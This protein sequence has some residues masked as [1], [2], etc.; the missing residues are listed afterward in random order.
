MSFETPILAIACGPTVTTW[1]IAKSTT[2]QQSSTFDVPSLVGTGKGIEQF[3]P[4]GNDLVNDLAWNHNGQVIV[5]CSNS[6]SLQHSH[7]VVL[8]HYA[9]KSKLESFS[10]FHTTSKGDE[11]TSI[12]FGG[13]SAKSRYI[14]VSDTSGIASVWDMKKVSRVRSFKMKHPVNNGGGGGGNNILARPA[15]IK[16]TMDPSDTHVVALHGSSPTFATHRIALE[17]FHLK[18]GSRAALLSTPDYQYGGGADC[19]EFS[20]VDD[21]SLLLGTKDGS[22]LLWDCTASGIANGV[23]KK[24]YGPCTVLEQRHKDNIRNVAFSPM[25]RVLAASCSMDGTVGFHDVGSK[26]TIQTIRPWDNCGKDM[27]MMNGRKKG[28]TSFSFHHDGF[29]WAVGTETGI[30]F[31]YD[32]RQTGNGPL[33]TLRVSPTGE[34]SVQKLQ[35]VQAKAV[36]NNTS[37]PKSTVKKKVNME[38]DGVVT[39]EREKT[40][41]TRK[42]ISKTT[43]SVTNDDEQPSS[44]AATSSIG[45]YSSNPISDVQKSSTRREKVTTTTTTRKIVTSSPQRIGSSVLSSPSPERKVESTSTKEFTTVSPQRPGTTTRITKTKVSTSS[46]QDP[47]LSEFMSPPATSVVK[48]LFANSL[49]KAKSGEKRTMKDINDTTSKKSSAVTFDERIDKNIVPNDLSFDA[50]DGQSDFSNEE[51]EQMMEDFDAMYERIKNRALKKDIL[52]MMD[53]RSN[54]DQIVI[55]KD[56]DSG[57]GILADSKAAKRTDNDEIGRPD[58]PHGNSDNVNVGPKSDTVTMSVLEIQDMIDDAVESLRDDMEEAMQAL[59]LDFLKQM[60]KQTN[61]VAGMLEQYRQEIL[62][63]KMRNEFLEN[64]NKRLSGYT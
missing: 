55:D 1:D 9:T 35:F 4:H 12:S 7:N 41:P 53:F 40:T 25:N 62:T 2:S 38:Q 32:L 57:A 61:D 51:A 23:T 3:Q 60:Q 14:C 5:T 10:N 45:S 8:T 49:E 27:N 44:T 59:Q 43:I 54:E 18:S 6:T 36:S 39:V 11:A 31:T 20:S 28:L 48:D 24:D 29:T 63:L 56:D 52:N 15:C 47:S 13:K 58:I 26:K 22:L 30:V 17:L 16:S 21:G 34:D 19:F 33:C 46:S 42:E 64:E 50:E 37:V